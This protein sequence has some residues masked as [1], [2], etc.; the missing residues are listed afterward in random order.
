M[1]NVQQE[2]KSQDTMRIKCAHTGNY[3]SLKWTKES[4]VTVPKRSQ[5]S[6]SKV[7]LLNVLKVLR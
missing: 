5:T 2:K 1:I 4:T 3:D 6:D 7:N